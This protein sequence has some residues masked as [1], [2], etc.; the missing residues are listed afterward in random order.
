MLCQRRIDCKVHL[1]PDKRSVPGR[2]A[3]YD[4]LVRQLKL[5]IAKARDGGGGGSQDS[6]EIGDAGNGGSLVG[7]AGTVFEGLVRKKKERK[8]EKDVGG[9]QT[10]VGDE[11]TSQVGDNGTTVGGSSTGPNHTKTNTNNASTPSLTNNSDK[12]IKPPT[13]KKRKPVMKPEDFIPSVVIDNPESEFM[14]LIRTARLANGRANDGARAMIYGWGSSGPNEEKGKTG[15]E[16]VKMEGQISEDGLKSHPEGQDEDADGDIDMESGGNAIAPVTITNKQPQPQP[17]P[18]T[19]TPIPTF[20]F[21][22]KI[23]PFVPRFNPTLGDP[24]A[25]TN[26]TNTTPNMTN[27]NTTAPPTTTAKSKKKSTSVKKTIPNYMPNTIKDMNFAGGSTMGSWSL[28]RRK[29]GGM[30]S[31]LKGIFEGVR[32]NK[33][34]VESGQ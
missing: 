21:L 28:E 7:G 29:I 10:G 20:D 8:E 16:V 9:G 2:S 18:S 22:P 6:G 34:A 3:H 31:V 32:R 12:L 26:P 1:M 4:E 13:K 25:T 15:G 19:S 27:N 33:T 14:E 24:F 23:N 17:Q 11:M 5:E 30:E